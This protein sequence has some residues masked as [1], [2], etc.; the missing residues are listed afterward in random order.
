GTLVT[1]GTELV[2]LD[3]LD[4]MKVDF[5]VPAVHLGVLHPGLTLTATSPS[6]PEQR[7]SGEVS[8]IATRVDPISRSVMVRALLPNPEREL[9]PGMLMEIV[10]ERRP[11]QALVIPE[12]SLIPSGERQYVMLIDEER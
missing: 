12:S 7:F 11:R 9:R 5:T 2:T 8:S 3:K 4:V 6:Y 1:P 10:L